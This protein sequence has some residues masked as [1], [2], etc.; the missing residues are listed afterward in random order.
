MKIPF[1]R[2]DIQHKKY[3]REIVKATRRVLKSG[4]YILGNELSSFEKNFSDYIG[5]EHTIG[6]NSGTD[7]L[8]LA[9]RALGIGNGDDVIVPSN[10]Y[11]ATVIAVTENGANP[12]FVEPNEYFLIDPTLIENSI[13]PN[14]KAIIPVHLYGQSCDMDAI[15]EIAKKHSLYVIEDCAQSHGA[16]YKGKMTGSLG[17]IGCFSFYPTKNL[18]AY[19]DGG[20]ITLNDDE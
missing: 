15:N 17:D 12:I 1:N 4:T 2:L 13:T 18:G 14:T 9:L 6:V 8:I 19:G 10:T 3:H 7:A 20:A 16:T 5:C 11:I